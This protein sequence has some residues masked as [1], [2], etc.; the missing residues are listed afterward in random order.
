MTRI[1]IPGVSVISGPG[2]SEQPGRVESEILESESAVKRDSVRDKTNTATQRIRSIN[3]HSL[4]ALESS[5]WLATSHC[6]IS[7]VN[8]LLK[9][10]SDISVVDK[11]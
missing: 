5:Q 4:G 3:T 11:E 7:Y 8:H 6:I 10:K 2:R 9:C 1:M